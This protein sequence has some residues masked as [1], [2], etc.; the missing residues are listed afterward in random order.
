M[1]DRPVSTDAL[2]TLGTIIGETEKRDAIHLAVLPA[3]A[4]E[5][6]PPGTHVGISNKMA[7]TEFKHIGIVD[8]F[9]GNV[10]NKGERFWIVIYPRQITSLRHVWT[11]PN[12][13]EIDTLSVETSSYAWLK[14]F[15]ADNDCPNYE[16]LIE[17][18]VNN[19]DDDYLHF[20]GEDAH[21]SI[22]PEF[23]DHVENVTGTKI[24]TERRAKS[25]SCSC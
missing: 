20:D 23:W 15:I 3:I 4:A 18:A 11:H 17:V 22:P 21:G 14:E 8:P 19:H 6:L 12:I 24:P 13:P 7:S 25:F 16:T 9:L 2:E 1:S 5:R 10:V